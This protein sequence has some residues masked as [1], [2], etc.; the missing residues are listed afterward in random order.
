MIDLLESDILSLFTSYPYWLKWSL[1][2]FNQ[3]RTR[4]Y[5]SKSIPI[6]S[7]CATV[8]VNVKSAIVKLL[9]AAHVRPFNIESKNPSA[10]SIFCFFSSSAAAP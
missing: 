3:V 1:H 6:I 7:I 5:G 9:M 8:T 4:V 2:R 10:S